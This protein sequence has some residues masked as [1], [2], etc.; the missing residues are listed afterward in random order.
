MFVAPVYTEYSLICQF[1][2]NIAF[3]FPAC[4]K[5]VVAPV[6]TEYSLI[7]QFVLQ[8]CLYFSFL[9]Q[10]SCCSSIDRV[11]YANL[12]AILLNILP[13]ICLIGIDHTHD[14]VLPSSLMRY[15]RKKENRETNYIK[16]RKKGRKWAEFKGEKE[17]ESWAEDFFSSSKG[18][19]T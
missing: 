8:Y 19:R 7:C 2:C 18:R 14:Q 6:Y 11:L 13:G 12:F 1:V 15:T 16:S 5:M 17:R 9:L 4:R 10:N 3:I